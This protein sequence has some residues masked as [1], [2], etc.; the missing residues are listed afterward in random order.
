MVDIARERANLRRVGLKITYREAW[1]ARN[2]YTSPRTVQHPAQSFWLHISVT[3]DPDDFPADEAEAMRVV[4]RIGNQRFGA[5]IGFPYNA[6]AFQSGRLYE[7]Q[8]LSR[9][10]AHTVNNYGLR[11]PGGGNLNQTGRAIALVQNVQDAVT[12]AQLHACAKWAAALILSG[13]AVRTAKW[14][15]HRQVTAKSCPGPKA[16]ALM[17]QLQALTDRY[18]KLGIGDQIT[19]Q[20]EEMTP[21]QMRE[22]KQHISHEVGEAEGRILRTLQDRNPPSGVTIEQRVIDEANG[23]KEFL[24]AVIQAED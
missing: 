3:P 5:G 19:D 6:G 13:E 12:E 22:L 7:G 4:E 17:G 15:A 10:G 1:G 16:W 21:A 2:S 8:P 14:Y 9:R 23:V 24:T 18:V 11:L 20:E